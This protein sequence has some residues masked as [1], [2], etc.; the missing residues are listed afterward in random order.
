MLYLIR[1]GQ[2]AQNHAQLLQGRSD[3]SLN[4]TGLAQAAELGRWFGEQGI[5]FD[6]VYSSPLCRAVETARQIVGPAFPIA[7]DERLIEMDYGPYEGA[8]LASPAPELLAF[9]HDFVHTPAPAGMEPLSAVTARCG[10]FLEEHKAEAAEGNLL[11]STHAIAL[12]GALE[13]L[14][15]DSRGAYWSRYIG[16]CAVFC[17]DVVGGRYRVPT[18]LRR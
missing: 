8:D 14:T 1:H 10:R 15:P 16:N 2:T 5:R 11:L 6:A 7:L 3:F 4:D 12:K 13:Y 17:T 18:E 9:F